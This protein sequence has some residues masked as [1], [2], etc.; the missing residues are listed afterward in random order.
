MS[1]PTGF[2]PLSVCHVLVLFVLD[3][4]PEYV[5]LVCAP[6]RLQLHVVLHDALWRVHFY[7]FPDPQL[8]SLVRVL[9]EYLLRQHDHLGS[10]AH[11]KQPSLLILVRH[12]VRQLYQTFGTHF[13]F[14]KT[15]LGN[16]N[17]NLKLSP[18]PLFHVTVTFD[19]CPYHI[20][21]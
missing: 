6:V 9:Q 5:F 13:R 10:P 2:W 4:F 14:S 11:L 15:E 12:V 21:A 19:H 7:L 3:I 16:D 8:T 1:H 20:T 18:R 17:L